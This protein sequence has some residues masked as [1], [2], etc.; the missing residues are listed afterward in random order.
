MKKLLSLILVLAMTLCAFAAFA[1][2]ETVPMFSLSMTLPEG[3]SAEELWPDPYVVNVLLTNEDASRPVIAVQISYEDIFGDVT[4]SRDAW[5]TE[6]IQNYAAALAYDVEA[7][8]YDDFFTRD[9]GLG[10]VMMIIDEADYT[11]MLTIW[12][13]YMVSLFAAENAGNGE[14]A[15]VSDET[16]EMIMQFLTDMDMSKVIVE[17][18]AE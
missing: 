9:T 7:G 2:E 14:T 17:N 16:L 4:F 11:R 1:E 12:H 18:A 3:Y 15:P 13:G 8:G 6:E 5:E 10:T